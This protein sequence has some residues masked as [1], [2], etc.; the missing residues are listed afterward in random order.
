MPNNE[1][2]RQNLNTFEQLS[3]MTTSV[4]DGV[5]R[6]L[7]GE[8]VFGM[9]Q[10]IS[11]DEHLAKL[12]PID[13]LVIDEAHHC[14]A[15]SYRIVVK[16]LQELNPEMKILGV[17]ATPVRSD[18]R[19]LGF[20]NVAD[21]IKVEELIRSGHLVEPKT[22]VI[23]VQ[24][25]EELDDLDDMNGVEKLLNVKPI[26]E[27]VIKHWKEKAS[28]RQTV[29]FCSTLNHAKDVLESFKEAKIKA[30]MV[31]GKMGRK[32]RL[33]VLQDFEYGKLQVLVN[34]SVLTEGW[35]C[36]SVSCVVLL[37]PCAHQS[38]M[39]Q[40]IGRGL[41]ISDNKIDC[42]V[43]DFGAS[44]LL[45]GTLEQ[46]AELDTKPFRYRGCKK[47]KTV[48]TQ[49][50]HECPFCGTIEEDETVGKDKSLQISDFSMHTIDLVNHSNY[51]W[52]P[53]VED[54]IYGCYSPNITVFLIGIGRV[55]DDGSVSAELSMYELPVDKVEKFWLTIVMRRNSKGKYQVNLGTKFSERL[56]FE[57]G[58]KILELNHAEKVSITPALPKERKYI[59][60]SN[61]VSD[62]LAQ[63]FVARHIYKLVR[64]YT[65]YLKDIN[66]RIEACLDRMKKNES[67]D[68]FSQSIRDE[69]RLMV[70]DLVDG[71][72]HKYFT[73]NEIAVEDQIHFKNIMLI[74]KEE[75]LTE[76]LR[77]HMVLYGKEFTLGG[78]QNLILHAWD[79]DVVDGD[80]LKA[81][82]TL[83]KVLDYFY[84]GDWREEVL[85]NSNN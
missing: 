14:G 70:Q 55:L 82:D 10:T 16:H 51:M 28:K 19:Q 57:I 3:A 79:E 80:R 46:S 52:V 11:K 27:A 67:I 41:R 71:L 39:I 22:H 81:L 65:I 63:G 6:S 34:V 75:N 20:T 61:L 37:R 9:I 42:I 73:D 59:Q 12:Q 69:N 15:E 45:H 5:N 85:Q 49:A 54:F 66:S 53:M 50:V 25:L 64:L 4:Y 17:T 1:L 47:C 29:V 43:L 35:D 60:N 72:F 68:E 40:M 78:L 56:N 83:E 36:P 38:T 32:E 2:T 24:S 62:K 74:D 23:D 8:V 30:E 44:S 26:N 13:L 33:I 76:D 21:T 84:F 31:S 7:D 77:N 48:L 18:N 58:N